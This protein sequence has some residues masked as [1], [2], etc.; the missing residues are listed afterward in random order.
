MRALIRPLASVAPHMTL[1][2]GE[3][4]RG[5][6]AL[7]AP[8]GF[9]VGVFIPAKMIIGFKMRFVCEFSVANWGSESLFFSVAER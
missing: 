8:M 1:E 3:L 5:V 7:G 9:L 6:V 4:D 2:F